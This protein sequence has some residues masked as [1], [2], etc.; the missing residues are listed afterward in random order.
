MLAQVCGAMSDLADEALAAAIAWA[1][2]RLAARY[3]TPRS[4]AG[5]CQS[6]VV[7]AMGKLGGRELN[8]SSDIDLIFVY[9]EDG[10]TDGHQTLSNHEYFTR[11]ARRFIA[12]L[13]EITEDP[14]A[15]ADRWWWASTCSRTISSPRGGNGSATPGSRRGR[16]PAAARSS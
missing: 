16:S 9:P 13:S 12:A 6:L 3:G 8:V 15:M 7:V 11:L 5:E 10:E 4:A 2:T 1:Q 14:T